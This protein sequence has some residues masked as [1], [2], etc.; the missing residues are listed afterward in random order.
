MVKRPFDATELGGIFL[1]SDYHMGENKLTG[2]VESDQA[3]KC[4]EGYSRKSKTPPSC[5]IESI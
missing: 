2:A 5:R 4:T 3:L 1:D